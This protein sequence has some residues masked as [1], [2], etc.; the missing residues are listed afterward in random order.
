MLETGFYYIIV[1]G[2]AST[3]NYEIGVKY[4]EAINLV[5]NSPNTQ[6]AG[7]MNGDDSGHF[8]QDLNFYYKIDIPY[9][10]N[11]I[12]LTNSA[13]AN[14]QITIFDDDWNM[15]Y[16]I[17][18]EGYGEV[19]TIIYTHTGENPLTFYLEICGY[20]RSGEFTI[21][22]KNPLEPTPTSKVQLSLILILAFLPIMTFI[23][24]K[25]SNH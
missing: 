16:F 12:T 10:N 22:I 9:G 19:L 25:K 24:R 17:P 7:S 14:Y 13:T 11:T 18:A 4:Y 15:E 6:T 5:C 8:K 20:E 23:T 2:K 1:F 3:S 21:E